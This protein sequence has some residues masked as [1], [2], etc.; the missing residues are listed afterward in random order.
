MKQLSN[1]I[2]NNTSQNLT[3][4]EKINI[5]KCLQKLQLFELVI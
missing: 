1:F 5:I 3:I 4:T 2:G